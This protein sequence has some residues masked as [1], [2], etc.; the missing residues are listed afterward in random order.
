MEEVGVAA[1]TLFMDVEVITINTNYGCSFHFAIR[2]GVPGLRLTQ[3]YS[4][5]MVLSAK[6]YHYHKKSNYQ[7]RK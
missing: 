4:S 7:A 1:G 2:T 3:H 6:D 5:V